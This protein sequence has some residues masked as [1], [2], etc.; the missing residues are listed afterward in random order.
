MFLVAPN[1]RV[2]QTNTIALSSAPAAWTVARVPGKCKAK[3]QTTAAARAVG[4]RAASTVQGAVVAVA[5]AVAAIARRAL[6]RYLVDVAQR[7]CA[8]MP[9]ATNRPTGGKVTGGAKPKRLVVALATGAVPLTAYR[10]TRE[11]PADQVAGHIHTSGQRTRVEPRGGARTLTTQGEC[12]WT[13]SRRLQSCAVVK[14]ATRQSTR[15]TR[16]SGSQS[17]Q[18]GGK[19]RWKGRKR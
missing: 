16:P 4:A 12:R 8:T 15:A 6:N 17:M 3:R 7:R 9:A 14:Q 18:T 5:A 1:I 2:K 13:R 11:E 10:A 19:T